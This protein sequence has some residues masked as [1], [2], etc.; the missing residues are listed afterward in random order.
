MKK[1]TPQFLTCEISG[2]RNKE[3]NLAGINITKIASCS[4]DPT[5][6][7]KTLY[8][9]SFFT[10]LISLFRLLL[11]RKSDLLNDLWKFW[12]GSFGIASKLVINH[13]KEVLNSL[14]DPVSNSISD[15]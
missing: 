4:S 12:I 6:N 15:L 11:S 7:F 9:N 5:N 10:N 1:V 14:S 3:K 2:S 13:K 8:T